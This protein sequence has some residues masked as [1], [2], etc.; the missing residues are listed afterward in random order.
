M[1]EF[2]PVSLSIV[3]VVLLVACRPTQ[4]PQYPHSYYAA[5]QLLPEQ[6][7]SFIKK[8]ISIYKLY[9]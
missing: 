4:I 8:F 3:A 2:Y 7:I 6:L 5:G 9:L 1:L